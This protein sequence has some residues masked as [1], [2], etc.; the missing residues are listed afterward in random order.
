MPE[1]HAS[2]VAGCA[3]GASAGLSSCVLGAQVECLIIGLVSAFFI[4]MWLRE[5]NT[6]GRAAAAVAF[7]S[8]AAGY[9]APFLV[10]VSAHY[11]PDFV[12]SQYLVAFLVGGAGPTLIPVALKRAGQVVQEGQA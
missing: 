10:S 8:L 12:P 4:T 5:I 6:L 2:T 3:L 11:F 7:S 1:P 9:V